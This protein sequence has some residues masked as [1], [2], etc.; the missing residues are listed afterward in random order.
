MFGKTA[1]LYGV[2]RLAS[3]RLLSPGGRSRTVTRA[4]GLPELFCGDHYQAQAVWTANGAARAGC[5]LVTREGG[6]GV[7]DASSDAAG[8]GGAP[9]PPSWGS[10]TVTKYRQ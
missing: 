6:Q 2:V 10:A 9:A 4:A 5:S 7:R 8:V 3:A 1:S